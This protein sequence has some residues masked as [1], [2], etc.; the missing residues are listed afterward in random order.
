MILV[1]QE[2]DDRKRSE[3]FG[4]FACLEHFMR[5]AFYLYA[6]PLDYPFNSNIPEGTV[7]AAVFIL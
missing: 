7:S 1:Y 4:M 3:I 5:H 2:S 6:Y